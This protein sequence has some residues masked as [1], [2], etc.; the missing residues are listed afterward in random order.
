MEDG[1]YNNDD[2]FVVW[3]KLQFYRPWERDHFQVHCA[4][5]N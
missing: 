1:E 3:L 4:G 2:G 5:L